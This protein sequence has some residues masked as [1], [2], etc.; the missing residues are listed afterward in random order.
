MKILAAVFAAIVLN[1]GGA[2]QAAGIKSAGID[3]VGIN[4]PDLK[5][6]EAFL[7]T[8][9]GCE[10]VT[11]IGPFPMTPRA[12]SLTLAM[13]RCGTGANIELFEYKNPAGASVMPKSEDIGASHIAFYTDDV[14]AGV[15]YLKA[16]GITVLGEPMTMT[17]GD[18]EGETWVHFLSP[19]GSEMELVGYPN[20]KGYEK[21][22][23]IKLWNPKH[24]AN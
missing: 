24:P 3:H 14:K 12:E 1:L 8:T 22:S 21:K 18:T 23:R 11:H 17:S 16:Q 10:A 6:A 5:Q 20:G 2:A 13:V 7:A 9:F 4:V 15:A 19:W